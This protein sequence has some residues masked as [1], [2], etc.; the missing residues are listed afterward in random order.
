MRKEP[1]EGIDTILTFVY[2]RGIDD[3]FVSEIKGRVETHGG[4]VCFVRLYCSPYELEMRVVRKP[5]KN[6]GKITSKSI[7]ALLSNRIDIS[8]EISFEESLSLD[9]TDNSPRTVANMIARHYKLQ[10]MK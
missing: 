8:S 10:R 7:L 4:K 3:R 5:R 6:L 1:R 2:G 9:T